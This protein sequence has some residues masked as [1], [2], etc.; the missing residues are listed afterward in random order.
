M[1]FY[2]KPD[3]TRGSVSAFSNLFRYAL[4][5]ERGN[6]WVDADVVCLSAHEPPGDLFFGWEDDRY[7]GSAILRLPYQHPVL[8]ELLRRSSEAGRDLPWGATGPKLLTAVVKE[9]KF[10]RQGYPAHYSY[11][12]HWQEHKSLVLKSDWQKIS[13]KLRGVPFLHLWNER[14]KSSTDFNLERPEPGSVVAELLY[15]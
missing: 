6:W 3:G 1:F 2:T 7:V 10:M 4:L 13:Q 15:R 5:S 12:V 11:P 9:L 14:F 8:R